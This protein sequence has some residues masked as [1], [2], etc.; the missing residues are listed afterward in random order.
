[1]SVSEER[2]EKA[3][4]YLAETDRE[5]ARRETEFN[6]LERMRLPAKGAAFEKLGKLGTNTE[7]ECAAFNSEEYRSHLN[8]IAVAE[9]AYLEM[10][11]KRETEKLVWEHW[12]SINANR[13]H[14]NV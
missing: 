7:R 5:F 8:A 1:M 13:R 6:A 11:Y 2:A 4:T 10:R 14:G 3:L 12:R 9:T